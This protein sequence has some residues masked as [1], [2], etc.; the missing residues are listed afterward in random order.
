[1]LYIVLGFFVLMVV[2][3][4]YGIISSKNIVMNT[5]NLESDFNIKIAQIS[6]THFDED[7]TLDEYQDIVTLINE[8][9]PDIVFFTGDLFQ[10]HEV[11]SELEGNIISLFE[12]IDCINKVAVLGNH[13]LRDGDELT[14]TVVRILESSGFT[15][16]RNEFVDITIN[17]EEY[18]FIGMDDY[19]EGDNNYTTILN[20][21]DD[22]YINIV[23]SHEP[24]T[25]DYVI[26]KNIE[27]MFC[28]HSHGGQIRLPII[29][30]IYN[31]PGAKKYNE[32][33]YNIN[34]KDLFISFG[35]GE[36]VIKIRF[37][38]HRQLEIYSYS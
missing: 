26:D 17:D 12:D 2:V 18:R 5:H 21:I 33:H 13:D 24:D 3:G 34:D 19:M 14:N 22:S 29:G 32:H 8:Q 37:F 28:G 30:D 1:M 10:V 38:N 27:A 20:A 11:S 16:L 7:Y 6:D 9:N 25:F 36:S 31:V 35:L 23:L 15:V 4:L